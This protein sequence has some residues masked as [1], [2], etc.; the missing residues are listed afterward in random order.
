M[1]GL[2]L[3]DKPV[4]PT[5]HDVVARVRRALREPRIGHTG[6]L[7]PAASGVL[8]LVIGRATRLARFLTAGRKRYDTVIQLG[9]S[10]DTY[11]AEGTPA[12]SASR[13][14][15][16]PRPEAIDAAL[17]A[18]RGTFL[19]QPP[20][21]SAK[22]IGGRRSY[23]IARSGA[24]RAEARPAPVAVT[25]YQLELARIDGSCLTLRVDCSA[26]FYVRTLAHDLGGQLGTGAHVKTLRRTHCAG[27]SLADTLTLDAAERAPEA[28]RDAVVPLGRMLSDMA[29]VVLTAD[30]R[31]RA[32]HGQYLG[33]EHLR[34]GDAPPGHMAIRL[35]D[36]EGELIGIGE[37]AGR[38][39][40]LHP[41]V[42]LV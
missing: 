24:E 1:D 15:E 27:Y 23:D 40:L 39:G 13:L 31:A 38:P 2:L 8:P 4:G 21:Y 10:T 34:S 7:D 5:S 18:F 25:V 32:A 42:V 30:G 22:K 26:G 12:A 9:M 17:A 11:D 3:I 37:P 36:Q 28:A 20:L 41:S 29:A 35:V 14:I 16:M 19:Q 6:T 33:R